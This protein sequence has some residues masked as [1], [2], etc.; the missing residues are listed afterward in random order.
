MEQARKLLKKYYGYDSFRPGQEE[1]VCS[2]LQGRD[3]FGIMPTGAG[4][5]LC[6]QIPAL[7]LPGVSLVVSPLIS[8]MKDQ[9]STLNQMGIHAAYL[10]SSLTPGQYRK[11]LANTAAGQYKIVYVAPERLQTEA[12]LAAV[13]EMNI[14][15]LA[16]DEA[17]CISQWGQDFR[18]SYLKIR[19]FVDRLKQRPV[20]GAFTATATRD[21]REDV[22]ALLNLRD[23]LQIVTGFDRKNL[24]FLVEH[25]R[26]KWAETLRMVKSHEGECGIIY[27]LTRKT[28]E[29]VCQQLVRQGFSATRYHAGL[30]DE[31]RRHNQEDFIYDRR[32]IMVATN[33]FGMGIDKSNVRYVIHYNMPKNIESYYQEAGRGGR[34]GLPSDCLLLYGSQDVVTNQFFIDKMEPPEGTDPETAA[35][36]RERDQE[37]L[38]KMTFYCFTSNCLRD[39]ILRYFGEYGSGYCGNCTNCLSTFQEE[40]ITETTLTILHFL[41]SS[42]RSYGITT[43]TDALHGSKSAKISRTGLDRNPFYGKLGEISVYRLRQIGNFLIQEGILQVEGKEYPVVALAPGAREILQG[44]SITMKTLVSRPRLTEAG[45]GKK[46]KRSD[47]ASAGKGDADPELFQRLRQLRLELAKAEQVPPY[48]IF[49]DKTL[50]QM[51]L[52]HPLTKEEM[53]EVSGVGEVKYSKYGDQFLAVLRDAENKSTI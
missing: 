42:H 50:T 10:N 29:E 15:L 1:L 40:D 26:D 18:P 43:V 24:R 7:L 27:C 52:L 25:P 31:E 12:F 36:I 47:P 19:E 32:Q 28:V 45:G 53:M 8:L 48:I 5:S 44:K 30:S 49:S 3:V 14:S 6:Y 33:A 38:K 17:H 2:L 21:V 37:R 41:R 51:C 4:K 20:M 46:K 9:V 34:D 35:Q 23:P 13:Q 16:V 39:Y 11:A 22:L